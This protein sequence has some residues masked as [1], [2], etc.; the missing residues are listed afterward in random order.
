MYGSN[1]RKLWE[2]PPTLHTLSLYAEA[3]VIAKFKTRQCILMTDS[4]NLML[5]EVSRYTVYEEL[6]II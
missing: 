2:N 5:A 4:P 6:V 1:Y 3:L